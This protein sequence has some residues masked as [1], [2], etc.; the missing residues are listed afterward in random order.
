MKTKFALDSI[1]IVY[2]DKCYEFWFDGNSKITLGNGTFE[3]PTPNAF[4]LVQVDDCPGA[5]T[6]CKE[7]CYVHNLEKAEIEVHNKYR[8]NSENMRALMKAPLEVR[9][10]VTLKFANWI[11]LHCKEG[12]R[13]HV[14]G[15][16]F[17]PQYAEFIASVC[18]FTNNINF[19]IYTRS[20]DFIKP[21]AGLDNLVVNLSADKDN[22]NEVVKVHDDYGF[23]ICYL[24]MDG[25]FPKLPPGS[26]I[27]P[28]Y[29]LRG[30]DL[31]KPIKSKWWQG[32]TLDEQKMVCPPDF[33]GQSEIMR[34][35]P[36]DKCLVK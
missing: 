32:L 30:R 17:S 27:F 35:G 12:F 19:W 11:N 7:V 8:S 22:W 15:D 33:F 3:N 16:I 14:S 25:T 26:V 18:L 24:T 10:H 13:W 20:F 28:N 21:F 9:W 1:T 23:R 4:S 6:I 31:E 2:G 36:C 5:T 29:E 34:C